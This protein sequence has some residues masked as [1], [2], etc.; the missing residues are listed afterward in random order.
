M[1]QSQKNVMSEMKV[2]ADRE[3]KS[4]STIDIAVQNVIQQTKDEM[5][6]EFQI[7]LHGM[8]GSTDEFTN[9]YQL[10]IKKVEIQAKNDVK[11]DLEKEMNMKIDLLI[12]NYESL[13]KQVVDLTFDL[14]QKTFE[15][16]EYHD[17]DSNNNK[18]HNKNGTGTNTGT[19]TTCTGT[20]GTNRK[21]RWRRI[22]EYRTYYN[23]VSIK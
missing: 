20:T 12:E 6:Q 3:V 9:M 7:V 18:S 16:E 21:K 22:E 14:E 1:E 8:K 10:L 15:L 23:R 13:K 11:E 2:N 19:S 4:Q 17:H 5:N